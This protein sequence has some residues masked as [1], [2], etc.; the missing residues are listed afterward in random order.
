MKFDLY[1]G[2]C[3]DIMK[4]IPDGSIN[5]ILTDI[6]YDE[7]NQKSAG[8]RKLDRGIADMA[9]FNLDDFLGGIINKFSGSCYI[10]VV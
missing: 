1:N 5:M 10:F 7:V 8:L 4:E 6:P 2:N 3:L 9:T